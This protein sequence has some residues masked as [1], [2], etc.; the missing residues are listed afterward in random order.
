ML[1]I[2]KY[3]FPFI[4]N[5]YI[6]VFVVFLVIIIF[7]D[8]NSLV[9]QAKNRAKINKIKEEQNYYIEEI[10][11]DRESLRKMSDPKFIE[12]IGREEYLMK[13]DDEDIFIIVFDSINSK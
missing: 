3:I 4:K 2:F 9:Y 5:K 6:I 11:K 12:K 10:K 1:K 8:K 13:A 7:F